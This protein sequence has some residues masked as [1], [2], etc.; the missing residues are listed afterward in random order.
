M[1]QSA[2]V[3]EAAEQLSRR[4]F[5]WVNLRTT[6]AQQISQLGELCGLHSL[7]IEDI[8]TDSYE[9]CE[10]YHRRGYL[11]CMVDSQDI[12]GNSAFIHVLLFHDWVFTIHDRE[13]AAIFFAV[14]RLQEE[15][16]GASGNPS[17]TSPLAA[18][19]R[20]TG[21]PAWVLYNLLDVDVD[22]LLPV[23]EQQV[24]EAREVDELVFVTASEEQP[25]V[26][27]R[28]SHA[29]S[30]IHGLKQRTFAKQRLLMVV[31]SASTELFIPVQV[32]LYLRDICDHIMWCA[33]QLNS[34]DEILVQANNNYLACVSIEAARLSNRTNSLMKHLAFLATI[35]VPFTLVAGLMGMNVRIPFQEVPHTGPFWGIVAFFGLFCVGCYA[36]FYH[37]DR[38]KR[39]GR[40]L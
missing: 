10:L 11:Y 35:F 21:S 38:R 39:P 20:Y 14:G 23:V 18:A 16:G 15:V 13:S 4:S 19:P 9:K 34:A 29:R 25:A 30:R 1:Q 8:I 2:M 33:Q 7:T 32:K 37:V 40:V 31:S 5:T 3:S 12:R 27:R 22:W 28:I 6:D 26:L 17:F 24:Q 36:T